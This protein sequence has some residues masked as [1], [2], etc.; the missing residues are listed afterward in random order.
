MMRSA[1]IRNIFCLYVL[2][3]IFPLAIIAICL[4]T[5]YTGLCDHD[6]FL[7]LTIN[8]HLLFFGIIYAVSSIC[9]IL[10]TLSIAYGICAR[11]ST[12]ILI[13]TC[14][15]FTLYNIAVTVIIFVFRYGTIFSCDLFKSV[16]YLVFL[17]NFFVFYLV[18]TII[19]SAYNT[20]KHI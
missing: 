10:S 13:M 8:Q 5:V 15:T 2:L 18:P 7:G 12:Y 14:G 1:T 6:W 19:I 4:S 17:I 11:A 3:L 20:I 16:E 9:I